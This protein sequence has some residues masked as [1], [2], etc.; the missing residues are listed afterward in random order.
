MDYELD[1][2]IGNTKCILAN[3]SLINSRAEAE[4]KYFEHLHP[5]F[6]FHCVEQGKSTFLC[7]KK[8]ISVSKNQILIIPPRIYHKEIC[9]DEKTVKTTIMVDISESGAS[10]FEK[11]F[12]N[13]FQRERPL[14]IS[15][16]KDLMEAVEKI[17]RL[18]VC[19]NKSHTAIEKL[20]AAAHLFMAEL[21]DELSNTSPKLAAASNDSTLSREY[22]IDTHLALNF[23]SNS[24]R[25]EL[26]KKLHVSQRQLHRIMVKSY[27]KG[28][29][30]KLLELRLEI[31]LSF[32]ISTNKSISEISEELGY[33][34]TESFSAFIKR[35]TGKS[36]GEIRKCALCEK[37]NGK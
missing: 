27:G 31:A 36:P 25:A 13:A 32:L 8:Y 16:K 6:E 33:S 18:A 17:K 7:D 30:E 14:C 23:T 20:R 10:P 11:H 9:R 29:R 37:Q 5:C 19:K 28:Y 22:E 35:R 12:L 3:V 4:E 34:S 26:A 1:F 21:Y 24:S 2:R 15:P